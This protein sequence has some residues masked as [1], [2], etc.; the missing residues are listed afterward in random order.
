MEDFILSTEEQCKSA[1]S[2]ISNCTYYVYNNDNQECECRDSKDT[3]GCDLIKAPQK[4]SLTFQCGVN[5]WS[6]VQWQKFQQIF[7]NNKS[8]FFCEIYK[9]VL[10]FSMYANKNDISYCFINHIHILFEVLF[11]L[12]KHP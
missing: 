8:A 11:T 3:Q 2:M 4:P 6:L 10:Y 5:Y 12:K 1:C 7:S 9:L